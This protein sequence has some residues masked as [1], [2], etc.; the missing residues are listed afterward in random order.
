MDRP[1]TSRISSG[2]GRRPTGPP[3]DA[4]GIDTLSGIDP[5]IMNAD[6]K[7]WIFAPKD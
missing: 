7:S 5:F 1:R 3:T 6:G 4:K 2:N